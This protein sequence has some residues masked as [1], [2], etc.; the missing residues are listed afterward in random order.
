LMT[1]CVGNA[2]AEQRGNNVYVTK[3]AAGV[4][5]IDPLIALFTGAILMDGNPEPAGNLDDFLSDPVL[6][7]R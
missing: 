7:A 1:W 4:A 2:K 6:V 5:K 3:E